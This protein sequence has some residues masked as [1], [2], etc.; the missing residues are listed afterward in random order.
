MKLLPRAF[1]PEPKVFYYL[2][3]I[4]TKLDMF[5]PMWDNTIGNIWVEIRKS[6]SDTVV[7]SEKGKYETGW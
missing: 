7:L 4:P 2:P 6:I 3:P 5:F 1:I